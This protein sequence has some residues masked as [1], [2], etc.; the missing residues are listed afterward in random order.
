[1]SEEKKDE[2]FGLLEQARQ[3]LMDSRD[4]EAALKAC[5]K[6]LKIY[7]QIN[8]Q[9]GEA[10]ATNNIGVIRHYQAAKRYNQALTIFERISSN[11]QQEAQ[12]NLKSVQGKPGWSSPSGDTGIL[13]FRAS[14][15]DEDGGLTGPITSGPVSV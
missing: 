12:D 6:A 5:Q 3:D 13:I 7:Q 15:G 1:M 14:V 10:C 8:Y 2:A 9:V 11:G 4:F